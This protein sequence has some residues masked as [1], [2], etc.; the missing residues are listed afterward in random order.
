MYIPRHFE[1]TD[2][3]EI[4]TFIEANAFGQLISTVKGRLF[5]THMPFLLGA[6]GDHLLGHL[7]RPNP[8]WKEVEGQEVLVKV[9]DL[10]ARGRIKLSIKEI[11]DDEKQEFASAE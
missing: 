3:K 10:D 8:Q 6:D 2:K 7:A 1:I 11:T 9:L 5:A 4:F